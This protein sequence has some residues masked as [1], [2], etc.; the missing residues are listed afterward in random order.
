VKL[1]LWLSVRRR[2]WTA[3]RRLR[4]GLDTH[5]TCPLCDQEPE[6]LDHLVVTCSFS[7]QL[8]HAAAQAF[9][10]QGVPTPAGTLSDWWSAWRELWDGDLRKGADTFFAL[11]AW[12]L[13][14]ER[15]ARV[16]RGASTDIESIKAVV[17]HQAEQWVA[18]GAKNLG[19]LQARV[20]A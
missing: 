3:D 10:S 13:W 1:F 14:K 18:A 5:T 15:N 11:A 12:E 9:R 8:W 16:F 20:V 2:H 19:R 17:R 7:R 4:H 6:T